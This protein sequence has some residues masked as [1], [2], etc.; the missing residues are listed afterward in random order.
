MFNVTIDLSASLVKKIQAQA[1]GGVGGGYQQTLWKLSQQIS[2]KN[3]IE[4]DIG[5][6]NAVKKYAKMGGGIGG[7]QKTFFALDRKIIAIS[8]KLK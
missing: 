3:K 2:P 4:L 7:F 5:L 6:I 8:N 1:N